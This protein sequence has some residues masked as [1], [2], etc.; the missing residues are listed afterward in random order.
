MN[1]FRVGSFRARDWKC[2]AGGV[3]YGELRWRESRKILN[4]AHGR[5]RGRRPTFSRPLQKR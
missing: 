5:A 1:V 4:H 2:R 3:Y